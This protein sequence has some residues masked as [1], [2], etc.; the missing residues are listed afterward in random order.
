LQETAIH[1]VPRRPM[2][3]EDL[4]V[5]LSVLSAMVTPAVLI[6]ASSSLILATSGRLTRAVDRTRA[7]SERI[8][9]EAKDE[10]RTLLPEERDLLLQQLGRTARRAKLLTRTLTRLYMALAIFIATSVAIGVVAVTGVA[11]AW[12]AL[13]LGFIGALLLFWSSVLLIMES[14]IALTTVYEEMEFVQRMSQRYA[15]PANIAQRP[16]RPRWRRR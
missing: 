5:T 8:T 14:R 9:D 3:I 6:L 13:V 11:Y 12:I 2:Q 7:I 10:E 16:V 4:S 1:P 15:P